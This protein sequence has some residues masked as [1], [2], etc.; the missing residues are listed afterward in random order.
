[1]GRIYIRAVPGRVVILIQSRITPGLA[2]RPRV[3]L[4]RRRVQQTLDCLNRGERLYIAYSTHSD[5]FVFP[6]ICLFS[7]WR[8]QRDSRSTYPQL[9]LVRWT[10]AFTA[11]HETITCLPGNPTF[12]PEINSWKLIVKCEGNSAK[13]PPEFSPRLSMELSSPWGHLAK[14]KSDKWEMLFKIPSR[15]VRSNRRF[16]Q[17]K[18]LQSGEPDHRVSPQYYFGYQSCISTERTASNPPDSLPLTLP[19]K[20]SKGQQYSH[21]IY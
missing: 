5:F 11:A 19:S 7:V 2:L 18:A 1:M 16:D 15:L 9:C 21:G 10:R 8:N 4:A 20:L 13:C 3:S 17:P 14:R 12:G 6:K